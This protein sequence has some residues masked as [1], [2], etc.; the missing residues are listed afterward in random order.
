M[1]KLFKW[2]S[3]LT[4]LLAVAVVVL[5]YNPGLIK[6]PLE[7][8]L[9]DLAGYSISLEGDLEIDIGRQSRLTAKNIHIS[10]P[11]WASH[12]DLVEIGNLRLALDSASL[13]SDILIL[14]SLQVD[15]LQLN[16]ETDAEGTGNWLTANA[17]PSP[18]GEDNDSPAVILRNIE[19][20][21]T[22]IRF[23]N[24]KTDV[25]HVLNI[26]SLKQHQQP[27]GMLYT[28]L[29]GDLNTRPIECTAT[30]GPYENLLNGREIS[31]RIDG[32]LG[33]LKISID[34]LIDDLLHPRRPIFNL[35]M[36]GP[37]IDE[38][39]AMLGLDDLGAGGFSL[40]A[41]GDEVGDL[42]EA[43]I[44]GKVGDIS[45][46][47][48]VQ[49]SDLSQLNEFDLKLGING[50][51]L[52]AFTR[53]FGIED[54]PDKPFSLKGD[55]ERIGGTLNV[56]NLT[57]S[58]GGTQLALDALLTN[59]PTLDASRIKLSISGD[60]V[61]QFRELLG[62]SG[63]AT[64]PFKVNA[65]LDVSPEGLE[66]LQL[67]LD[68]S[69]GHATLSGTLG[70]APGYVG[71]KLQLHLDGN[72]AHSLVSV[73]GI[74]ALPEQAFNLNTRVELVE[75][76]IRIERGVLVTIEDDRLEL[77]GFISFKPGIK[78]TDIEIRVSGQDLAE[79]LRR[80]VGDFEV[81]DRPYELSGRVQVL[82]EGVQLDNVEAQFEAIK[83]TADGLIKP[84]D[85][86]L[87]T[88]FNFKLDGEKPK[89]I[90]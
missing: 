43:D 4:A 22:T 12:R 82:E 20:S 7:R 70:P 21:N 18:T 54:W 84:G 34:G 49:A 27:G 50:P 53:V 77:G 71:S 37:N 40:H 19:V 83:L 5:V 76:G 6:G 38:I 57:L 25:E 67:E 88:A 42:Y 51:S 24:G 87:D 64:G 74:D 2:L 14:E 3:L 80:L 52:G 15:G 69:L 26:A 17:Q 90:L 29:N 11:D 59:F 39:T 86:F 9:S 68:T 16:L 13:F 36:Q 66:L 8:Y 78:G 44:N 1:K 81:P 63:V 75:N 45:L 55:A 32:H 73:F 65:K 10:G 31:Y 46:S 79:V 35:D 28:T 72:N 30:V 89:R 33:G 23:H 58:I 62:I 41:K 60:D 85:R 56:N 61:A 48:S 47:A